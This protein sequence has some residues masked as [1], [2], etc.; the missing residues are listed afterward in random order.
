L[1]VFVLLLTV[2]LFLISKQLLARKRYEMIA[3]GHTGGDR[4][5][6]RSR[7]LLLW[8]MFGVVIF[9]SLL[10]HLAVVVHSFAERWFMSPLPSSWTTQTY[11]EILRDP[12]ARKSI[13]NS[14]FYSSVSAFLDLVL[15]VIIAWVLTRRRFPF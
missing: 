15:G 13:Q 14:L 1:V 6:N 10:P 4:K 9:L 12:L 5:P 8:T 11:A 3:R 2:A 7:T